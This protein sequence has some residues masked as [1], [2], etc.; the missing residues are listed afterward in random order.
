MTVES[1]TYINSL[2]ASYPGES[3]TGT[4]HEGNDHIR[5]I[6]TAIKATFPNVT[7]AVT[8][9]HTELNLLDG[10][11]A[12]VAE[13]NYVD[14]T[15]LGTMQASKALT[16][17]SGNALTVPSG[18]TVTVASGGTLNVEGAVQIAG[19]AITASAAEL[20]LLDGVTTLGP[21]AA[22]AQ[23]S[24]SGSAI[25]FTGIPAT[26]K[27]IMMLL[28][29]VSTAAAASLRAQLGDAG[30]L[31]ATDYVSGRIIG[32]DANANDVSSDTAG[33]TLTPGGGVSAGGDSYSG[34]ITVSNLTGNTW[35]AQGSIWCDA[36]SSTNDRYIGIAGYKTLSDTLDRVALVTGGTFDA[37]TINIIYE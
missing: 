27:R 4:L 1:V 14:V 24:T 20:N 8:A 26:A 9:T 22:T 10:V 16:A 18:G 15:T 3:E 5:N 2:N 28:A 30:G 37:G 19:T 21:V 31:E 23:A 36:A 29:G 13:L 12:S 34:I 17:S 32:L 33:F 7:G 6:K 35:A 11:T 25:T